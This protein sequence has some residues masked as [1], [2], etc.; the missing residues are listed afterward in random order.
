MRTRA[1]PI[2]VFLLCGVLLL[3]HIPAWVHASV[4]HATNCAAAVS[5][6]SFPEQN[7]KSPSTRQCNHCHSACQF[8]E[9][10]GRLVD[11]DGKSIKQ[12]VF[13]VDPRDGQTHDGEHCVACQSLASAA[14]GLMVDATQLT[15]VDCFNFVMLL[16]I[17]IWLSDQHHNQ[18]PRGP[19]AC[20]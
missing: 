9:V 2:F 3:G 1:R 17:S 20:I 11:S 14:C 16:P 18:Q 7:S 19:P 15:E 5:D 8:S 13:D 12:S 6:V 10:D 4:C